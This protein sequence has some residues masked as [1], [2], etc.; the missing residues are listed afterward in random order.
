MNVVSRKDL[1]DSKWN[2][3]V[4]NTK[5]SSIFSHTSYLDSVAEN[6]CVLVNESYSSGMALPYTIRFGVKNLYTPNFSRYI[7]WLYLDAE[8]KQ[9]PKDLF[10]QLQFYFKVASFNSRFIIHEKFNAFFVHQIND[11]LKEYNKLSKRM[12]KKFENSQYTINNSSK[13]EQVLAF[14]NHNL[15]RKVLHLNRLDYERL[16]NLINALQKENLLTIKAVYDENGEIEGGCFFVEQNDSILYLKGACSLKSQNTGAMYA[17]MNEGILYAKS[18]KKFFDYGGS[19]ITGVRQ[20]FMNIGG[21]DKKYYYY[22]W[23]KS[24]FPFKTAFFLKNIISKKTKNN[25]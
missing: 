12:L 13:K 23:N 18:K 5:G 15:S 25:R 20:F 9:I 2:F 16:E 6:W 4:L 22:Q 1:D 11:G 8:N 10:K 21:Y 24:P 19:R 17:L 3:L 14:I 7:E